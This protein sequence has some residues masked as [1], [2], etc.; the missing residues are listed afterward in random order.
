MTIT[1]GVICIPMVITAFL[2]LVGYFMNEGTFDI[3]TPIFT[4]FLIMLTWMIYF[5]VT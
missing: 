2:L 1:I 3:G 4:I 5:A